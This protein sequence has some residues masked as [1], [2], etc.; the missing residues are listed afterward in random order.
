MARSRTQYT[1]LTVASVSTAARVTLAATLGMVIFA[2]APMRALADATCTGWHAEL[3]AAENDVDIKR[4]G[5]TV[6][7]KATSGE[8]LCYGDAISVKV[9][10]R[11]TLTL[12]DRTTLRLDEN[13][14]L[15]LAPPATSGGSLIDLLRGVIHV[16]SRDPRSLTFMTPY[17]NA[18]LEG[19]EFDIRVNEHEAQT[20]VVVLE[21][22]V[23][24]TTPSGKL[25]VPSGQVAIARA[26]QAPT[27]QPV[28]EAIDLM[29]WTGHY[30]RIV[31][32]A[33]PAPEGT[34]PTAASAAYFAR[35]AAAQL[36]TARTAAA[37][38]DL[39][40]AL[41]LEPHQPTA[42]A[43]QAIMALARADHATALR[44]ARAATASPDADAAP[45]LA[46]SYAEESVPDLDAAAA[47]AAR[48]LALEPNNALALSR[49]AA[50]ALAN[51]DAS[52]SIELASRSARL[53]PARA[54]APTVL[55]FAYLSRLN[56]AAARAAF[57][58]AVTIE[59]GAPL[60]RLGR[61]LAMI[62][63][64]DL[65]AGRQQIELAVALDPTNALARSYMARIYE[66]ID[67]AKLTDSQLDLA[68]RFDPLDPTPWLYTAMQKLRANRPVEAFR[69]MQAA[70][71]KNGD[72]IT[73]RS[74]LPLDADLATRS[75]SIA[76]IDGALGF[77]R[78]ALVDAWQAVTDRP[79]DYAGHRLLADAYA[80]DSRQEVA[81][82]SERFQAQLLQPA[83]LAPIPAQLG[84]PSTFFAMHFGPTPLDYNEL[85]S[86]ITQNGLR[87][88]TSASTGG[89][90]TSGAEVAVAGL[91]DQVSYSFGGYR[92]ASDGFRDNDDRDERIAN[93]FVQF[94]PALDT[95]L[96][97][98]LRS[99]RADHGDLAHY[100]VPEL[101]TSL[102]MRD[103]SDS[104]RFGVRHDFNTRDTLLASV[105]HQ[106][107]GSH[108]HIGDAASLSGD[109]S[110]SGVDVELIHDA[111][112]FKVQ[113]GLSHASGSE[114]TETR[115]AAPV[116][117]PDVS[118]TAD[119]SS[120]TDLYGY[121]LL[122]PAR[123]L[124]ITAGATWNRIDN[125]LLTE[126]ALNPKFGLTWRPTRRTTL[127]AA[128][129]RAL[130]SSLTI[131]RLNPQPRL[132][133][134]QIAGF[135][136]LNFAGPADQSTVHGLAL[137]H[138]LSERLF[139]GWEASQR[140]TGRSLMDPLAPPGLQIYRVALG[141]RVHE[142]YLYW[143]P[144]DRLGVSARIEHG[145]FT[146]EP[147]VHGTPL[148]NYTD[149]TLERVPIELRYFSP[150][151]LVL[152][153]RMSHI[154]EHGT[155]IANTPT[156]D[157][158]EP[159]S[160][161][162][163]IADASVGYRLPHRRGLLS[164]NADNLLDHRFRFQDVDPEDSRVVPERLFS[165][166]FTLAFD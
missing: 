39:D 57:E 67:R 83:N 118:V 97:V 94:R 2:L 32:A 43:L 143:T 127:R 52:T 68:K 20:E 64:G 45:W 55:G 142:A 103:E 69:E 98:E 74:R 12:P 29:R 24:V 37:N 35:R 71:A 14:T 92:L 105:I 147:G 158:L 19:T 6:W 140:N 155:F 138:A 153:F 128:A 36:E 111:R 47:S 159:G 119:H 53:A 77:D 148:F 104:A 161:R 133:P 82:V 129:F 70:T 87:L 96:Q 10:S 125:L 7:R 42:V 122:D 166:R 101:F 164:L 31:D 8:S 72:R 44:L 5:E 1:A 157:V 18:G 65:I 109:V 144:H 130:F 30:P 90:G 100:F 56:S 50:L 11:A 110:S 139:V 117:P 4:A 76:D 51:D 79:N 123:S 73:L 163:W 41:R 9:S 120:Q 115:F 38:A 136:Q 113:A 145:R 107:G 99:T 132:E 66:A 25:G 160:D 85:R 106:N 146:S 131:S 49:S 93:A 15:T 48:A 75:S 151:G 17:A 58:S 89:N 59:P 86:P 150:A 135:G 156:R 60:P 34:A 40:T 27:Q 84:Q 165:F 3:T 22:K 61:G 149:L 134:V 81:R 13:T 26:G 102:R 162:F 54:E 80:R 23:A 124:S 95:S 62:Q 116:G 108:G 28:R 126:Q 152:G 21:G 88:Q 121:V 33:L 114:T 46:L 141:E 16:I 137:D 112:L 154:E 78:L 63:G 91:H